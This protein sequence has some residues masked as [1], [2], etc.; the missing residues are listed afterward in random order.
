MES[1][2]ITGMKRG[3]G[4]GITGMSLLIVWGQAFGNSISTNNHEGLGLDNYCGFLWLL[5]FMAI[6]VVAM[7]SNGYGGSL[8]VV[9]GLI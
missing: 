2:G 1:C 7:G 4:R 3:I 5:L 6:A 9:K 8:K